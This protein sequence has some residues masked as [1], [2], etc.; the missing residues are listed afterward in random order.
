M[1]CAGE[2]TRL[3]VLGKLLHTDFGMKPEFLHQGHKT[4]RAEIEKSARLSLFPL[5]TV[6]YRGRRTK[7]EREEEG[8]KEGEEKAV[9]LLLE[10]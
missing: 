6:A 4:S 5:N 3:R 9:R 10:T 8:R 7:G 2:G 1:A